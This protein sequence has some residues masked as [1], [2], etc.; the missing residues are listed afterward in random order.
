MRCIHVDQTQVGTIYKILSFSG[1][2]EN[3][4]NTASKNHSVGFVLCD[5][6]GV[7]GI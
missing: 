4:D 3:V 6:P 7:D 1:C 5:F 2:L